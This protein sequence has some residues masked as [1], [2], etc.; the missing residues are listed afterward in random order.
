MVSQG[1][2]CRAVFETETQTARDLLAVAL[3]T[4][5]YGRAL[6]LQ[7]EIVRLERDARRL[8]WPPRGASV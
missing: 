5:D 3:R 7:K 6:D 1:R 2:A 4:T 8:R